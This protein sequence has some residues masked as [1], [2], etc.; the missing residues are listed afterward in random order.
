MKNP[1][2]RR[3]RWLAPLL[4][5]L[6]LPGCGASLHDVVSAGDTVRAEAMIGAHPERVHAVNKLG[7]QPLHYAVTYKQTACMELLLKH[8]ADINAPD[9]TGMTPLHVA[10]MMGRKQ[11]AL[12]LLEHGAAIGPRDVFGDTPIHTAAVF[13]QG[14][15]VK[16]L[17]DRGARLEDKNGR[18]KT[19]LELA[20]ENRQ[21]RTERYIEK[22]L[23]E[24]GA[25]VR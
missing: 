14:H 23:G 19:P 8:G 24:A 10:A 11:E 15:L 22:L 16:L 18:G 9:C 5:C 17:L 4:W 20:R 6:L 25:V 12:W 13:G 21:E 3:G 7:K 1:G 2:W